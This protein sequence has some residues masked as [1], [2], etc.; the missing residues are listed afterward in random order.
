MTEEQAI[1]ARTR[2]AALD[3]ATRACVEGT[4]PAVILNTAKMFVEFIVGEADAKPSH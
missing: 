3:F 1:A 4:E 2:L